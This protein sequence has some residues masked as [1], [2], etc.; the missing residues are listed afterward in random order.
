MTT[1]ALP[2][3]KF[4]DATMQRAYDALREAVQIGNG[5][6]NPGG[7]NQWVT[8]GDL[9]GK[10]KYGAAVRTLI[11]GG[12]TGGDTGSGGGGGD[13][14]G[15][16]TGTNP[17][18]VDTWTGVAPLAPLN[19]NAVA[20][21]WA[22]HLT[23]D[24]PVIPDYAVTEIWGSKVD[25]G[26]PAWA[27]ATLA[28][29][30]AV[31]VKLGETAGSG[32]AHSTYNNAGLGSN[33]QWFFWV[34]NRD[35]ED[36]FSPY[37]PDTAQ[38]VTATTLT[39]PAKYLE[40]LTG[41]ILATQLDASLSSRIDLIDHDLLPGSVGARINSLR[42][43]MQTADTS[44]AQQISQVA[45]SGNQF[46]S[47]L[48]WYFD[49]S[50]D[51]TGWTS[52][53]AAI[54]VSGGNLVFAPSGANPSFTTATFTT[55]LSGAQYPVVRMRL[56]RTGG[57]GWIGRLTYTVSGGSTYTLTEV[58][59]TYDAMGWA[60]L[61]WDLS[62]QTNW[63]NNAIAKLK[64][65]LGTTATDG[66]L[67]DW[68]GVGR[69]APG[70]SVASV[71][72]LQ[73][74]QIG[75]C[76]V[77]GATTAHKTKSECQAAGGTWN[78]GMAWAT[79]VKQVA[80]QTAGFCVINGQKSAHTSQSTCEAA[81]GTWTAGQLGAIEEK[82][83]ALEAQDG[84]FK[85]QWTLKFDNKGQVSGI[86][87]ASDAINGVPF[88]EFSVRADR[89][90]IGSPTDTTAPAIPI[91]SI[92]VSGSTATASTGST[93]PNVTQYG[94]VTI[95][96]LTAANQVGWNGS[97]VVQS[98][99]SSGG[100]YYFTFSVAGASN[101]STVTSTAQGAKLFRSGNI[102]FIVT[103]TTQVIN[104][105]S[106]PPG[107]YI[108][109]A[110]IANAT[111][112]L[113]KIRDLKVVNAQVQGAIASSTWNGVMD[114]NGNVTN[115]G[116]TGWVWDRN[117]VLRVNGGA[118]ELFDANGNPVFVSGDLQRIL[119]NPNLLKNSG[120][121][122]FRDNA[123]APAPYRPA[124]WTL[125]QG[126]GHSSTAGCVQDTRNGDYS[127]WTYGGA[128]AFI[129][130]PNTVTANYDSLETADYLPV[131]AQVWYELS[132]YT[133]AHR[134]TVFAG[135][136]WFNA[137]QTYIS[138][139]YTD[140]NASEKAGGTVLNGYKRL[141]AL[142]QAPS[143]AVYAKVSL[144]KSG[145]N[146]GTDSYGFFVQAKFARA[147]SATQT[148]PTPWS[149]D[150]SLPWL[151]GKNI[152]TFMEAAAIKQAYIGD[153]EIGTLKLAGQAVTVPEVN[154]ASGQLNLF[155]YSPKTPNTVSTEYTMNTLALTPTD[156]PV[157][158]LILLTF[159]FEHFDSSGGW[160]Y[161]QIKSTVDS[162]TS[163]VRAFRFDPSKRMITVGGNNVGN[164]EDRTFFVPFATAA[165]KSYTLSATIRLESG[166]SGFVWNT[167]N[168]AN[169]YSHTLSCWTA[170]R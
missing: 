121:E 22:I 161:V 53:A 43:E 77:A 106:V 78:Q 119:G 139:S 51:I 120:F 62:A 58:E 130:Q 57:S 27:N 31:A 11:S 68:L 94:W 28:N 32:W 55:A 34:R 93:N 159:Q 79:A 157:T 89:F 40:L 95:S 19:L 155:G 125:L 56:K 69:N 71:T 101:I 103:T 76:T 131:E 85:L 118:F 35:T 66:F 13:T 135:I 113:A 115:F 72:D 63:T 30:I 36:L 17:P 144:F 160:V 158:R 163:V 37:T 165:N 140:S 90:S 133:G 87:F 112:E 73:Q 142:A 127:A 88:S 20:D 164:V 117:G 134:C 167:G 116:T 82:F 148:A 81:G 67:I 104:G 102:P 111:I 92:T 25:A 54:S 100:N 145:T 70:A 3:L 74:A 124:Y 99:Y 38:G 4:S 96:G 39:S 138:T 9:R 61:D 75:Y 150:T 156:L 126:S 65:E 122:T 8:F 18:P 151:S 107:V 1:R 149:R 12:G 146:A 46:D 49:T 26:V 29:N 45:A 169:V 24:N 21:T 5:D 41:A 97:W 162:V 154:T 59:P 123:G 52:S 23:W 64:F 109:T 166:D 42:T 137:S 15:G 128:G 16:D 168:I 136:A 84:A 60:S 91:T 14:G 98:V 10:T 114:S 153:A 33:E 6:R 86:G 80:V 152:S 129:Y 147:V 2:T 83:D 110:N 170:K 48:V 108:N 50:S 44:L 141:F 7:D 143:N 105:V 132:V 47:G